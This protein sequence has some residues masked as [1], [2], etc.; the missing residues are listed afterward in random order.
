[1]AKWVPTPSQ[2]AIRI[3]RR[4]SARACSGETPAGL[5][6]SP[7]PVTARATGV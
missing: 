4:S 2:P 1:M 6:R 3:G 5:G 7:A